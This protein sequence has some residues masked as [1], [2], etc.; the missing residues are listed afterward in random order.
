MFQPLSL[1]V[2]LRYVRARRHTL[3]VSFITW[4]S[5]A[6]VALG[7]AALI[8]VLSVMNGLKGELRERLLALSAHARIVDARPA[9][10][11]EVG[12][13][14]ERLRRLPG[15][16]GVAPYMDLQALAMHGSEMQPVTLRGI[17][18][19]R[20]PEVTQLAPL[21]VSGRISA[22]APGGNRLILGE[23]LAEQLGATVGDAITL[24]VPI[25][26]ESAAP[27][28]RLRVFI[29]AGMFAAGIQDHDETLALAALADVQAFAPQAVGASGL[30]LRFSDAPTVPG[31]IAAVRAASGAGPGVRGLEPRQSPFI[32]A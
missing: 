7:V 16:V 13:L 31:I 4:V 1:F 15:V 12:G 6:G 3:F 8:V 11:A 10:S 17:D 29:V 25:A 20:E 32:F 24:L 21:L 30:R 5:L 22:L 2:G 26:S 28:P 14:G 18:P 23:V 27:E 19:R 9:A